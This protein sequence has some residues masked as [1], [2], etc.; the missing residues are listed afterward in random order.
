MHITSHRPT[1]PVRQPV[2]RVRSSELMLADPSQPAVRIARRHIT[3]TLTGWGIPRQVVDDVVLI[4]SE[5]VT[6]AHRH[7]ADGPRKL[8]VLA[9]DGQVF[10]S[11]CDDSPAPPVWTAPEGTGAAEGGRGL[12]IVRSLADS[13]GWSREGAGK[14]VWAWVPVRSAP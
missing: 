5:L 12:R 10:V 3:A 8:S 13:V 14:A 6:N 11:V 2:R 4:V 9:A 1:A 7:T